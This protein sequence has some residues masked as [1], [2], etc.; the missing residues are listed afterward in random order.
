MKI[1]SGKT[2]LS[3]LILCAVFFVLLPQQVNAQASAQVSEE[4]ARLLRNARI[5]VLNQRT[6]PN[7]F[8]LPLLN[9]ETITLSSLKGKVV[10][11]NFWATWCPPCREEMPSMET[12]YKRY[13]DM[14]L[15]M[16][17]VNLR[18]N[19]NTVRQFIQRH[20]YTFPV[21]LDQHGR[22]GSVY[23]VEAIPTTYI[24]DREGKITGRIVGSIHWDTPQ[25]F[26]AF[27]A[28]LK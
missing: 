19:N 15:E 20:G 16:L 10:V 9:G 7:D 17:A 25:V 27:D 21:P 11:L 3:L 1:F 13:K 23:G 18:E 5:Q 6:E 12:L 26:A 8:T 24:I 2:I 28:L 4:L 22:V 14:G